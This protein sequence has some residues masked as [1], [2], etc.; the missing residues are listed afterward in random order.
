MALT[1]E[2]VK[3]KDIYPELGMFFEDIFHFSE[4]Y[5]GSDP[6]LGLS[7]MLGKKTV[8][9]VAKAFALRLLPSDAKDNAEHGIQFMSG[10]LR[11][12]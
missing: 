1:L 7:D 12:K 2:F 11:A 3:Q 9:N 5:T 8:L 6:T 4:T 10:D